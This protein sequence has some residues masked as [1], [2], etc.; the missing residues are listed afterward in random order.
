MEFPSCTYYSDSETGKGFTQWAL[1]PLGK[2]QQEELDIIDLKTV[3]IFM[4][5]SET[6]KTGTLAT[7]FHKPVGEANLYVWFGYGPLTIC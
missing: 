2:S 5:T 7:T 6:T 1:F 4:T 3:N